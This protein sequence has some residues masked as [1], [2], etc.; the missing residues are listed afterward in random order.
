MGSGIQPFLGIPISEGYTI[1]HLAAS[2]CEW[3]A[4]H[5][6]G[7]QELGWIGWR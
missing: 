5:T 2:N 4:G 3:G 6:G 1:W 7:H